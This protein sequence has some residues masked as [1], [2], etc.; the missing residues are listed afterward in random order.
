MVVLGYGFD[1]RS[2]PF[3]PFRLSG[4][5]S[6]PQVLPSLYRIRDS[7][8]SALNL[9]TVS[10][11]RGPTAGLTMPNMIQHARLVVCVSQSI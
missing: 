10:S 6:I 3:V 7:R 2:E 9:F 1:V 11:H 4:L 8:R 5:S